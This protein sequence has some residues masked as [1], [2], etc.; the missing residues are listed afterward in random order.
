MNT[1]RRDIFYNAIQ[2]AY[3]FTSCAEFKTVSKQELNERVDRVK[4]NFE[5]FQKE[6]FALITQQSAD[7]DENWADQMDL[8]ECVESM[9]IKTAARLR[10]RAASLSNSP[11]ADNGTGAS[12]SA[13]A[14]ALEVQEKAIN[15][16]QADLQRKEQEMATKSA[17]LQKKEQDIEAKKNDLAVASAEQIKSLNERE[18]KLEEEKKF[19]E[20][21]KINLHERADIMER[22]EIE[23]LQNRKRI[24]E[25]AKESRLHADQWEKKMEELKGREKHLD[26]RVT[27]FLLN[28]QEFDQ[29]TKRRNN[30]RKI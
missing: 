24:N 9:A 10:E 5:R 2:K 15:A 4:T 21:L 7:N 28:Q 26:K 29:S 16:K 22:N 11:S 1:K 6:H 23:I 18:S 14:K 3:E 12:T 19:L 8:H 27:G 13:Q 17:E 25:L 20:G 30:E